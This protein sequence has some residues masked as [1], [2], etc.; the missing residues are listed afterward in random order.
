MLV[1]LLS[2]IAL[3]ALTTML[4]Y[5][6]LRLLSVRLAALAV[7][8]RS[9]PLIVIF[10]AFVAHGIEIGIYGVSLY[11]LIVHLQVGTLNGSLPSSLVNCLYFSSEVYASL[12][13][14]DLLPQ[15]PI[16]LLAG[17]ESLNGL[18]LIGWTASY[19]YIAMERFWR[20]DT[21]ASR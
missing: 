13:F 16:R 20:C 11:L 14:G 18:L 15:G 21:G 12:G 3:V 5:E 7:P 4:H 1:V 6:A 17:V 2:C 19:L 8:G 10:A 9:K